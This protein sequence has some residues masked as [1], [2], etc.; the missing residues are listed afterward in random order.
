MKKIALIS[1]LSIALL[2]CSKESSTQNTELKDSTAA[3]ANTVQLILNFK[4]ELKNKQVDILNAD[5]QNSVYKSF[6][7]KDGKAFNESIGF[8]QPGVYRIQFDKVYVP[9]I[10]SFDE[11]KVELN[12]ENTSDDSLDFKVVDSQENKH[13]YTYIKNYSPNFKPN[14]KKKIAFLDSISPSLAA[15]E[16]Y[17]YE[18]SQFDLEYKNELAKIKSKYADISY[19]SKLISLINQKDIKPIV[20]GQKAPEFMLKALDGKEFGPQSFKGKYVLL[21]FWASWCGPCRQ[22][23]PNVKKAYDKYKSKGFEVLGIST[24]QTD[25]PWKRA[26]GQLGINWPSVRDASGEVSQIYQIKYI[27]TV[28]LLDPNGVIVADNVRGEKLE[29]LLEKY[30]GNK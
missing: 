20:V 26:V 29:Q 11:K 4:N 13:F 1:L 15:V 7:L 18:L 9:L 19:A 21:D 6:A 22:E 2:S 17:M 12:I 27:P 23:I 28:Y 24:D 5:E 16:I 10:V 8:I 25:A 30:L 3:S 14:S